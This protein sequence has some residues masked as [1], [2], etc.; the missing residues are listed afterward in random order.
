MAQNG[1]SCLL[2]NTSPPPTTCPHHTT[3]P[4]LLVSG[5]VRCAHKIWLQYPG[6]IALGYRAMMIF[7]VM[8]RAPPLASGNQPDID[9]A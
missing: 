7:A 1:S 4:R 8:R 6:D 5:R 3:P 2:P 9:D